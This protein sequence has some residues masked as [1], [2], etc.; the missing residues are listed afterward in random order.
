[1][2]TALII[3]TIL[4]TTAI[5][6][7]VADK[8]NELKYAPSITEQ[9]VIVANYGNV[10]A[11]IND[12][13]TKLCVRRDE[14]ITEYSLTKMLPGV[15]RTEKGNVLILPSKIGMEQALFW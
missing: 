12:S 14:Y 11:I 15:Y 13:R 6:G 4:V 3:L 1:M 2:R 10:I 7:F 9:G 8:A 5:F